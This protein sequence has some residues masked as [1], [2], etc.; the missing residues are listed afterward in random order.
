MIDTLWMYEI[1]VPIFTGIVLLSICVKAAGPI[2]K[3][4]K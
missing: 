4:L 3:L 2:I 1:F